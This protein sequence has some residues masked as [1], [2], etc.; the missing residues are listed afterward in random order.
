MKMKVECQN[1]GYEIIV[2][3]LG[4]PRKKLDGNK[5]LGTLTANRSV[6]KTATEYGVSRGS[7]RNAMIAVGLTTK[8]II[9]K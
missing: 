2:S 6:T 4:R 3:G 7:I 9:K 1:C 8:D 5:V